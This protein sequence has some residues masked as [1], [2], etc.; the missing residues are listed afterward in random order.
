MATEPTSLE[1]LA[2]ELQQLIISYLPHSDIYKVI[3]CSKNM[4]DIGLNYYRDLFFQNN[5]HVMK[6]KKR[7]EGLHK[8]KEEYSRNRYNFIKEY[9]NVHS[10]FVRTIT[11]NIKLDPF[12]KDLLKDV[13]PKRCEA[14]DHMA[15]Y[16]LHPGGF[17]NAAQCFDG[18]AIVTKDH[19]LAFGFYDV[20]K[21]K[22]N[23]IP[24]NHCVVQIECASNDV[25]YLVAENKNVSHGQVYT[26][27]RKGDAYAEPRPIDLPAPAKLVA[28]AMDYQFA[29]TIEN[30]VY[31]WVPQDEDSK[32]CLVKGLFYDTA[33]YDKNGNVVEQSTTQNEEKSEEEK[34]QEDLNRKIS[35]LESSTANNHIQEAK[36]IKK[37]VCGNTFALILYDSGELFYCGC[38][39]E[40]KQNLICE[41]AKYLENKNIVDIEASFTHCVA[42]EKTIVPPINEWDSK[43]I[44]RWFD[45]I[46]FHECSNL[47]KYHDDIDGEAIAEADEEYMEDVLGIT[48]IARQQ[49]FRHE[50]SKCKEPTY[51]DI[52]LYGWGS[53]TFGQLAL[54]DK[55]VAYPKK[56]PL[57]DL[58]YRDDYILRVH[59]GRRNTAIL[60]KKGEVWIA[61][62]CKQNLNK[63]VNNEIK[64]DSGSDDEETKNFKKE[65]MQAAKGKKGAK[66]L[67][68]HKN[69]QL[70]EIEDYDEYVELL[71]AQGKAK[72]N[73]KKTR[74]NIQKKVQKQEKMREEKKKVFDQEKSLEHRWVN[75]TDVLT[76]NESGNGLQYKVENIMLGVMNIAAVLSVR[77]EPVELKLENRPIRDKKKMQT[78]QSILLKLEKSKKYNVKEYTVI[79]QDRFEGNLEADLEYFLQSSDIPAHRIQRVLKN[80]EVIWD[81]KE[82]IDKF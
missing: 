38:K 28:G 53:N 50:R 49:R 68:R 55:F 4:Y 58:S 54:I 10:R 8:L 47:A 25:V 39:E 20:L 11:S 62:N 29:V 46:G 17:S 2:A 51:K 66:K 15:V 60:T 61:G 37:V 7:N 41:R 14:L 64:E 78:I 63:K 43:I 67:H 45:D 26:L 12:E 21:E 23:P 65:V 40:R 33:Q 31:A 6:L 1:G 76:H 52:N 56:I 44:S 18:K 48:D 19:E 13:K 72:K 27:A 82:R 75:F 81:K 77:N 69:K 24:E 42:F 34:I 73:F 59:C 57:P 3:R 5:Y 71:D 30:K 74:H 70:S 16:T 35:D 36:N 79:Y 22:A 80:D 32:P 9:G